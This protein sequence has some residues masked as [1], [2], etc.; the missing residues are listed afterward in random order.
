MDPPANRSFS[1]TLFKFFP[2]EL[3]KEVDATGNH[4]TCDLF[5]RP[6]TKAK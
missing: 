6:I 2:T 5:W 4:R 1:R 3:K